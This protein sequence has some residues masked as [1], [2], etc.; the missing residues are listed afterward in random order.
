MLLLPRKTSEPDAAE[1]T[2]LARERRITYDIIP[3]MSRFGNVFMGEADRKTLWAFLDSERCFSPSCPAPRF[4]RRTSSHCRPRER[5]A[6]CRLAV[7]VA[8]GLVVP[9]VA[10]TR[11]AESHRG[12]AAERNVD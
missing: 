3:G 8:N 10:T 12:V 7:L 9:D 2:E 11:G 4:L 1:T 6:L 5:G